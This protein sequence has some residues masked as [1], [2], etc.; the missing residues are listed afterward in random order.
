MDIQ[1][2]LLALEWHVTECSSVQYKF[3]RNG[4]Q[5]GFIHSIFSNTGDWRV[6]RCQRTQVKIR[7]KTSSALYLRIHCCLLLS[8]AE[9]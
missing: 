7:H 2:M 8:D 1:R 9:L 6:Y 4:G 3:G 5:R